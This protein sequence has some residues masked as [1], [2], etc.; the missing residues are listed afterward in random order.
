MNIAVIGTVESW[1]Q[2]CRVNTLWTRDRWSTDARFFKLGDI[3]F[4]HV[5]CDDDMRGITWS[6]L[7]ELWDSFRVRLD[8]PF[9]MSS[10]EDRR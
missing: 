9:K 3:T 1:K 6:A 2:W 8:A 7:I 5:R 4:R 10:G